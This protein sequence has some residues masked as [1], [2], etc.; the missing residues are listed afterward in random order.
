MGAFSKDKLREMK[1][2]EGPV[3]IVDV[4]LVTSQ[5]DKDVKDEESGAPSKVK[6][7]VL[8]LQITAESLETGDKVVGFVKMAQEAYLD[9][10]EVH[11]NEHGA[12]TILV[13]PWPMD[14]SG[15]G[16]L[17]DSLAESGFDMSSLVAE[18]YDSDDE[19]TMATDFAALIG[20]C[21]VIEHFEQGKFNNKPWGWDRVTSL[22]SEKEVAQMEKSRGAGKKAKSAP[23]AAASA[24]VVKSKETPAPV[25]SKAKAKPAPTPAPDPEPEEAEEEEGDEDDG[26]VE[27]A[28]REVI[29][30]QI[31]KALKDEPGGFAFSKVPSKIGGYVNAYTYKDGDGEDAHLD[32]DE[33]T[34]LMQL[35]VDA[36]QLDLAVAENHTDE[37]EDGWKR[38][39]TKIV[40][41]EAKAAPKPAATP[42]KKKFGK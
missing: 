21:C 4:G 24:A 37:T 39:G 8:K 2:L 26:D 34:A 15:M 31:D 19:E 27:K 3:R 41:V 42:A 35:A 32:D 10:L 16:F 13:G 40:R 17:Y 33:K 7:D 29:Y 22:L 20:T 1:K 11:E 9:Q 25:A 23:G 28:Y 38:E 12:K 6:I 36:K 5:V 18:E 14:K 30:N